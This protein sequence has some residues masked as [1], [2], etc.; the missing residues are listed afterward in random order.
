MGGIMQPQSLG[1]TVIF[2][3]NFAQMGGAER[4]AEELH[5]AF[6]GADLATTL[7]VPERLSQY[8]QSTK[9]KTTWMQILPAKAR[10]FRWYFLLYPLAID[11]VD[12]KP[13]DLIVTSCFGYAKGV[14]RGR[15]AIHV[16]YC[17]T[18]MRWVW[19]TSDY[20]ARETMSGWRRSLL[21]LALKALKVWE[22]RASKRPDYYIANSLETARRL[23]DAFRIES[24]LIY[25]PIETH[26]FS[27]CRDID[28][29]YLVLSRLVPYKRIDLAIE[30]CQRTGRRL[31][32]IGAGPDLKR[33]QGIAG[34]T[35]EFLGRC[36]DEE[37]AILL[38]R[39]RALILP[40]EEDFGMAPLEANASGRPVIAFKGGGASETITPRLNGLFFQ[41]P[42]VESL[43]SSLDTFETIEWEP[44]K[45]RV[46]AERFDSGIFRQQVRTF[47][48]NIASGTFEQK[49]AEE[50]EA[51]YAFVGSPS[52]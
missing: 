12:L 3:D 6:P 10:L 40:G 36:S 30:A 50:S 37:V 44:D 13:Y 17:H 15:S 2:H 16:C 46:Y 25:P 8:L 27:V 39:C 48:E 20:L 38:S 18:P 31:K 35:T 43:I 22:L 51:R 47:V 45:I 21:L 1:K 41:E 32:I 5:R 26:R 24:T 28:N 4:V 42:T 11:R 33:L 7:S 9:M 19:R 49:A 29:H 14:K 23:R 52:H 34:P